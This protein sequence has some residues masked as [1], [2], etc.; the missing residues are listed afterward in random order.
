MITTKKHGNGEKILVSCW[1][2]LDKNKNLLVFLDES[3]PGYKEQLKKYD[4]NGYIIVSLQ[5]ETFYQ[6]EEITFTKDSVIEKLD[7]YFM[8]ESIDV[9]VRKLGFKND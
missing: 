2:I 3:V 1:A 4:K 5:G 7:P 8:K 6:K 9:I